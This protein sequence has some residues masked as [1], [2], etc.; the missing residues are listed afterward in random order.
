MW[1]DFGGSGSYFTTDY[2]FKNQAPTTNELK[3]GN[4]IY[5]IKTNY[6]EDD[7]FTH[8]IHRKEINTENWEEVV[9]GIFSY[10]L[11]NIDDPKG[12]VYNI[13]EKGEM[14]LDLL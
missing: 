8:S 4:Y 12:I 3:I 6:N 9:T 13:N 11:D 10:R 2:N 5:D 14:E 1:F 7:S